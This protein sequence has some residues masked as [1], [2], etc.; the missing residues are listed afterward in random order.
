MLT[1]RPS[2]GDSDS[3]SPPGRPSSILSGASTGGEIVGV[4]L[5]HHAVGR[6]Q[7]AEL[8]ELLALDEAARRSEP[9][10]DDQR[11]ADLGIVEPVHRGAARR[12]EW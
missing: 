2:S 7:R 11:V 6:G 4:R 1:R 12:T 5:D 9:G 3:V 8:D 10:D